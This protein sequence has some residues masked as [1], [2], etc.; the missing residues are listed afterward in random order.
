M[1]PRVAC[2]RFDLRLL[3]CVQTRVSCCCAS[4]S[5]AMVAGALLLHP[6]WTSFEVNPSAAAHFLLRPCG[7]RSLALGAQ[8]PLSSSRPTVS[9]SHCPLAAP[10]SPQPRHSLLIG[11]D[12]LLACRA[13]VSC[14][15]HLT[16]PRV[17]ACVAHRV[18]TCTPEDEK[19]LGPLLT[20]RQALDRYAQ[21]T[22]LCKHCREVGG[23]P[24]PWGHRLS[25]D[26][27]QLDVIDPAQS[28][29]LT[30]P[31]LSWMPPMITPLLG[32]QRLSLTPTSPSALP[33]S[34]CPHSRRSF[35]PQY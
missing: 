3:A 33:P 32:A 16:S 2:S 11:C 13:P 25:S 1:Q 14:P 23:A 17:R 29:P 20:K 21:H 18:P 10:L 15:P 4:G 9:S 5:S 28:L 24:P 35:H 34:H 6:I 22:L 7:A 26:S 30:H 19:L 12:P 31:W 8:L 27:R